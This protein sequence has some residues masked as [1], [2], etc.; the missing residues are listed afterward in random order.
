[1]QESPPLTLCLLRFA[2]A[3]CILAPIAAARG[4]LRSLPR[5]LAALAM[6]AL[7]GVALFHIGFNYAL[8]YGSASQG[9]LVFA[10]LPAA[11]ARTYPMTDVT[12]EDKARAAAERAGIVSLE[13]K[14]SRG[15]PLSDRL[16]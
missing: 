11:V 8:V 7:A 13:G 2:I 4:A 1:V 9:A 5:P 10:L 6:M 3:A 14:R 15:G 12:A 16:V